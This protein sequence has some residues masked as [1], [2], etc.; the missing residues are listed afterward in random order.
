MTGWVGRAEALQSRT[1]MAIVFTLQPHPFNPRADL[2]EL[3]FYSLGDFVSMLDFMSAGRMQHLELH[4]CMDPPGARGKGKQA[5]EH[6]ASHI[7]PC[8]GSL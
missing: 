5:P 4:V 8:G 6:W 1:P 7:F 2:S 3:R